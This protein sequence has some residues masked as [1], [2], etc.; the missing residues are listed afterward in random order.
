MS[1]MSGSDRLLLME[2]E[3]KAQQLEKDELTKKIK[4]LA[5]VEKTHSNALSRYS[6]QEQDISAGDGQKDRTAVLLNELR[7]WKEK[8]NKLQ[9]QQVRDEVSRKNQEQKIQSVQEENRKY[10]EKID[11]I[12]KSRNIGFDEEED[13]DRTEKH[14]MELQ[15]LLNEKKALQEKSL[16]QQNQHRNEV[17]Q[18]DRLVKDAEDRVNNLKKTLK[19]KQQ[20]NRISKLKIREL[21]RHV[22]HNQLQPLSHSIDIPGSG[23]GSSAVSTP[24]PFQQLSQPETM[25]AA[26]KLEQL[27]ASRVENTGHIQ[28]PSEP[29][30]DLSEVQVHDPPNPPDEEEKL[31]EAVI[32]YPNQAEAN[33]VIDDK[34]KKRGSVDEEENKSSFLIT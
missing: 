24:N 33:V 28:A 11:E 32:S 14:E 19:E 25:E 27:M 15:R 6:K 13:E 21:G 1:Q 26:P 12:R 7:V 2:Q 9:Q 5:K 20:E 17:R 22:K 8:V 29:N 31:P 23:V 4:H 30:Q 10:Q 16:Q 3:L 18:M 34:E